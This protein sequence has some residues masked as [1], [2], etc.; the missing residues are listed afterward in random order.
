MNKTKS[1]F[2]PLASSCVD[3]RLVLPNIDNMGSISS[4]LSHYEILDGIREVPLD[5]FSYSP[6]YSSA[7]QKRTQNLADQ[8]KESNTISPLIVVEDEEGFYI[9]EGGH[10]LDALF[11]LNAQSFPALVVKDLESLK[12]TTN[13]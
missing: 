5:F 2:L 1:D 6:S 9:L 10:R 13:Q 11:L 8:I 3:G 12:S 7:E 4:S